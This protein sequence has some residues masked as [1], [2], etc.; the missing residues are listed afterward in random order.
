MKNIKNLLLEHED[1]KEL[2][3]TENKKVNTVFPIVITGNSNLAND[4]KHLY[5]GKMNC[6]DGLELRKNGVIGAIVK[7]QSEDVFFDQITAYGN[8]YQFIGYK[9]LTN[10]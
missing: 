7:G 1:F 8:S 5:Y 3:L 10:S 9:I 6:F 2:I 4:G